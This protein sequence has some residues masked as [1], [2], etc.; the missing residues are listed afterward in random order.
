MK[1]AFLMRSLELGG[2][3][4][5]GSGLANYFADRGNEVSI[6]TIHDRE[7]FFP[8][9]S[10]V[11]VCPLDLPDISGLNIFRRV[12]A[13]IR[14]SNAIRK[15]VRE[16]DPD[17]LIGMTSIMVCY[18]VMAALFTH[19]KAIGSE[20]ANPYKDGGRSM[21]LRMFRRAFSVLADGYVFQTNG[22]MNFFPKRIHS[23]S[24]IIPN[25]I[26]NPAVKDIVP[27]AVRQKTVVSM[28]RYS[29]E[30]SYDFLIKNFAGISDKIPEYRL[31]IYGDGD[32][33]EE[34]EALVSSLGMEGRI[35][36]RHSS[37]NVLEL[38]YDSSLFVLSS[39]TEGMPNAL[40]EAMA[41]GIPSISTDCPIGGPAEIIKNNENGILI[42]VNDDEALKREMLRVLGDEELSRRLS[43]N[44]LLVRE[45]YSIEKI[46]QQWLDYMTKIIG[47]QK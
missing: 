12:F 37:D 1:I 21:S 47:K 15:K 41:C 18:A 23:R 38:V 46:G 20:R 31:V 36:L 4:R 17:V 6:I 5:A 16:L 33:R 8:I 11:R 43:E 28:G 19:I 27:A 22:A 10:G 2:A 24:A 45:N 29:P 7:I 3:E 40:L 44:A 13:V 14:R 42:P 39:C 32:L 30:K 35:D 34:L 26:F 25:A 9:N